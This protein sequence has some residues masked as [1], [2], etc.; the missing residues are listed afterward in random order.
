[1]DFPEDGA[2]MHVL[3]LLL[4]HMIYNQFYQVYLVSLFV[5][6]SKLNSAVNQS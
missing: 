2:V 5:V 4:H 1:M 6:L 3:S